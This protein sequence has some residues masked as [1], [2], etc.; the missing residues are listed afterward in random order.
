MP[1]VGVVPLHVGVEAER[2]EGTVHLGEVD[3]RRDPPERI[4]ARLLV[5]L[6]ADVLRVQTRI[7]RGETRHD[8]VLV[9]EE[10]V[11]GDQVA[12][13]D[14]LTDEHRVLVRPVV[15]G[16]VQLVEASIDPGELERRA[17]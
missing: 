12:P 9:D 5:R 1:R 10:R 8:G 4:V 11:S 2:E 7:S 14:A 13:E 17:T 15:V 3:G 6:Q 16:D